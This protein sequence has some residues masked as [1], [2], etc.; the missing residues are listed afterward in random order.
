MGYLQ[1]MLTGFGIA[2]I[3]TIAL[4]AGYQELVFVYQGF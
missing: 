1:E 4:A 2:V 3:L